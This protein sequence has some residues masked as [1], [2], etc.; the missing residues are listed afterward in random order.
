VSLVAILAW[1]AVA[2][3]K[4]PAPRPTL[5]AAPPSPLYQSICADEELRAWARA[6]EE[7]YE[8]YWK[9]RP[10][11]AYETRVTAG[12]P[13]RLEA[14]T[15]LECARAEYAG[16]VE[17]LD[18]ANVEPYRIPRSKRF[19]YRPDAANLGELKMLDLGGG[20]VWFGI[21][22]SWSNAVD[23]RSGSASGVVKI[24]SGR[25][26]F[27]NEVSGVE[28]VQDHRGWRVTQI[29][30]CNCGALIHLDGLYR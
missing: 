13:K 2:G 29:G 25:G 23:A 4:P 24:S 14:C 10:Q 19:R 22:R 21:Q 17:D 18:S 1:L 5:C 15:N 9:A 16:W 3:A 11:E 28:L 26:Q 7:L 27:G 6:A 8:A 30:S 12:W 20:W